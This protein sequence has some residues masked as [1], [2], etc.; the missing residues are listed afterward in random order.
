[1]PNTVYKR[2]SLRVVKFQDQKKGV[3]GVQIWVQGKASPL[4]LAQFREM[5][6]AVEKAE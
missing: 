4:T 3:I 1:M 2:G 5:V 6:E